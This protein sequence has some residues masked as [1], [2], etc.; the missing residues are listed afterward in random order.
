MTL[1]EYALLS[2]EYQTAWWDLFDLWAA[3][4]AYSLALAAYIAG[5]GIGLAPVP[6]ANPLPPG[7]RP[8]QPPG[9]RPVLP[10]AQNPVQ[11]PK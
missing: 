11:P 1:D 6:P 2:P 10:P 5:G 8:V 7:P 3:W 9:P 4:E